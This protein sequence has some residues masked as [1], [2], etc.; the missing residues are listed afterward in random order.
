[1]LGTTQ[2]T[3]NR[4]PFFY[5]GDKYKLLPQLKMRFPNNIDRF[6]EP[7]CGGG[8]VF[9]NVNANEYLLN[10]ID[11]YMIKL[12]KFLLSSSNNTEVFWTDLKEQINK[13]HL[14]ATFIGKDVPSELRKEFVKT[15]FAKYNKEAYMQMR[16]DFNSNKDN[17]LLLYMLLIYG[18]NR[19]LRF[20]SKGDF[21]LP[22]GNVDFNANVE[23]AL[24]TYF[25]YV[26]NKNISFYNMD[27]QEFVNYVN[28]NKN[29]FVY[30]DPPYLITF[31][32]YN[33]LWDEDSEM[34]LIHFLDE[35]NDR[36]VKFAVSNV[37][38][39]RT[40]Y[41]GTFN[42]WAQKYNIIRI[43]S[44]YISY[45]DNSEKNSYEVLVKNY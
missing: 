22:V 37:L 7:F 39:H 32:E 12:H 15:Y 9:L 21:N 29:D 26:N 30:L 13:Y 11:T 5:V 17:M 16:S 38:W 35:L 2:E 1:M 36:N 10:D 41:N 14:S 42:E 44:N 19:M 3:F 34:R 4:S 6:I 33:K 8:S 28:P 40:R 23:R 24:N 31:S 27:F 18:F 20:N 43:K 45:H 25:E